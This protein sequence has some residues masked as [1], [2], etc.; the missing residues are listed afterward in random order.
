MS[1]N[2]KGKEPRR[3]IKKL[4]VACLL[5]NDVA[6]TGGIADYCGF[7]G[8][9][10]NKYRYVSRQLDT[11]VEEGVIE[12]I[13]DYRPEGSRWRKGTGYRLF[14]DFDHLG[15][16]CYGMDYYK[17][18][19]PKFRESA[20]L[21]ELIIDERILAGEE[22]NKELLHLLLQA[23]P[24][25]FKFCILN[26]VTQDTL[27]SWDTPSSNIQWVCRRLSL[28]PDSDKAVS[29]YNRLLE[30]FRFCLFQDWMETKPNGVVSRDLRMFLFMMMG[31]E[32]TENN[33]ILDSIMGMGTT[34]RTQPD[35][36]HALLKRYIKK[37][38]S[39]GN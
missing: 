26:P 18:L 1:E 5:D 8:T 9:T 38:N 39:S 25:F 12:A 11:L 33:R 6:N 21:R 19:R 20:W 30:V 10:D 13:E 2:T 28:T 16:V 36:L 14:R 15:T 3:D 22:K 23:S 31:N 24:T 37:E 29:T 35:K 34:T 32:T 27:Y 17:E 4:I 7:S